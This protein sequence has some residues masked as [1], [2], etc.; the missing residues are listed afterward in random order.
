MS[1]WETYGSTLSATAFVIPPLLLQ[2]SQLWPSQPPSLWLTGMTDSLHVI[3]FCISSFLNPLLSRTS[4]TLLIN[5]RG[6]NTSFAFFFEATDKSSNDAQAYRVPCTL[7]LCKVE[8]LYG[9]VL[10]LLKKNSMTVNGFLVLIAPLFN[11]SEYSCFNPF[12]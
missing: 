4:Q 6:Q 10:S 5:L 12:S 3:I 2:P 9:W 7:R 11:S 1:Q 8:S